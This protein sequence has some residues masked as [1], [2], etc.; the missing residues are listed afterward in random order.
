MLIPAIKKALNELSDLVS[1]LSD[2]EYCFP[3]YDLSNASIGEHTRHIIEM[4]QCLENQYEKGIVNYDNRKRDNL[5]QTN[6]TF[7]NECIA[8]IL[9]QI[10]KPNKN[11]QLQQIVDKEELFIESNYHRELL[12]N[13]EHCIHHQALI[14]VAILQYATI[15]IDENFGVAR[16]T[17]EYRNQCVQ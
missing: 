9:N 5:I 12:Y 17:I 15:A 8:V 3:C 16:S 6:T 1:K 4:F 13:F 14:K 11:L 2:N 10:E 7:A